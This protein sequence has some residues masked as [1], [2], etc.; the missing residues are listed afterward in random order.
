MAWQGHRKLSPIPKT[1][2]LSEIFDCQVNYKL[3]HIITSWKELWLINVRLYQS[4]HA[5]MATCPDG[6]CVLPLNWPRTEWPLYGL[7][8]VHIGRQYIM[9]KHPQRLKALEN[10]L[11][12]KHREILLPLTL[13][14]QLDW[15]FLLF[16]Q[17]K[18]TG[19]RQRRR[20]KF[21]KKRDFNLSIQS[22]Y[23]TESRD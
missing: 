14:C 3:R 5:L 4:N 9:D 16:C 18:Q 10:S 6:I 23:E 21:G 20:G 15:E 11:L 19:S 1:R 17:W 22:H 12:D 8:R 7:L 13:Y 2:I